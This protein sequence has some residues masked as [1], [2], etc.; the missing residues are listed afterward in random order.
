MTRCSTALADYLDAFDDADAPFL[1]Y[2]SFA[3]DKSVRREDFTRGEFRS[4]ALRAASVLRGAGLGCGDCFAHFFSGNRPADLAFRLAATMT[5]AVPVTVNW[6]ADTP[7]RV[8]YK[9]EL[10]ASRL[11]VTDAGTPVD[12]LDALR[13]QFPALVFCDVDRLAGEPELPEKDF[14]ADAALD[15]DASRIIIFTS[16]TTGRPRGVRLTYRNY[17]T[18]RATFESFLCVAPGDRFAPLVVNPLHHTNS[19]AITDWALRRPGTRLHLVERYA[20]RYWA[21]VAEVARGGF[22]RVVAPSVS[23]HFDYLESL[24]AENRLPVPLDDL[25]DAMR[26]VDFLIGSAPVGPT[27]VRRLVEYAGRIP[28]VRFGSTET[29]LQV[30]GTSPALSEETRLAA[31]RRGWAHTRRGEPQGGYYVGRPHPPFTECR[32]VRAVVR[33]RDGYLVDCD[34]GEPGYLIT[35]GDNVMSGYVKDPEAT[36]EVMHEG[37]WYS[38]LRDVCFR[39]V[40]EADGA[41]DFYWM[42][43]DSAM[44]IRGGVNYSYDQV[45]ADLRGFV[46]GRYGLAEDA[47][48]VAVV[49]L[50]LTSEHD[51]DCCVTVELKTPEAEKL[52]GEIERTFLVD[53]AD[54]VPKGSRPGFVRFA[55]IPRNFKGAIL[56]PELKD[57]CRQAFGD[58]G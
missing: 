52:K 56:V 8:V 19:T 29:C 22:D 11:V 42:S 4:L 54:A 9:I 12:A 41:D 21:I 34:E 13:R 27:T 10:T 33:G 17:V 23:R 38:G 15:H 26:R 40:S 53:A 14:C 18:N 47:F 39:L 37:G 3:P 2:F 49:G 45:N 1:T 57:A 16:G 50:R 7:E 58:R 51:D 55:P 6:Q 28:L 43:R 44:L 5:G 30:M 25:K 32:I 48:D 20:T 24:R 35:R 46:A 36:R 31:F